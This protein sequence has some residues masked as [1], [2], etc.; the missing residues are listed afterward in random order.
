M[1][2]RTPRLT[3]L[4]Y[5]EEL[6]ALRLVTDGLDELASQFSGR[7]PPPRAGC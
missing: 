7:G 4:A 3:E 6:V 5:N 1:V 2:A